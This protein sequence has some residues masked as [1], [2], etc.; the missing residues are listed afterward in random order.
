VGTTYQYNAKWWDQVDGHFGGGIPGFIKAFKFGCERERLADSF[1]PSRFVW[2]NDQ[3]SDVVANNNSAG[4][5]L[6]NGYDDIN[7]S[8]MGF[9]DGHAAYHSV[10]PGN[11]STP[12]PTNS[13]SNSDYTFVFEDLHLP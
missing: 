12:G 4:F 8:V 2:I 9:M 13:Y 3:Y 11:V 5:R 6:K 7:K 1:V 10:R